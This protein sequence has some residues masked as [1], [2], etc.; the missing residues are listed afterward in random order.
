MPTRP[1][2]KPVVYLLAWSL[3]SGPV[4]AQE[5]FS[6]FVPTPHSD[7]ERMVGFADLKDGDVVVDLGSGDGRIVLEAVRRH[8]GVRGRG[9]EINE[10]L[11]IESREKAEAE[12]IADRVDFLHQNAFDAELGE[13][14]VIF[15]WLFPEF[16]RL[17]RP[18]ILREARPG[19][20]VIT[21]TW[22]LGTWPADA[23]LE[24]GSK[25]VFMWVVP[26]QV[27]GNWDWDLP[28]GGSTRTYSAVLEQWFQKAEGVVRVGKR[29]NLLENM[30]LSGD[31]ISFTLEVTIDGV[32]LVTHRFEGRVLDETIEGTVNVQGGTDD[33]GVDLPWR[34]TR[35]PRSLYFAPTGVDID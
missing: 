32:G 19:T 15:L 22:D 8:P 4:F 31:E 10:K 9:I 27:E 28:V 21:R 3:A 26:A 33:R 20:R 12:N 24:D 18:K 35:V 16:M 23:T 1:L 17:L 6:L 11:A 34:A 7:V 13:A 5:R 25:D 29:R 14:T 30:K 2:L